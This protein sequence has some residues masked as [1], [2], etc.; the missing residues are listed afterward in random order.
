MK[1]QSKYVI[2]ALVAVAVAVAVV[3]SHSLGSQ[4]S[5]PSNALTEWLEGVLP[6]PTATEEPSPTATRVPPPTPTPR[7]TP[8]VF[9]SMLDI[10]LDLI[11]YTT[12]RSEQR[13]EFCSCFAQEMNRRLSD[14]AEFR[15]LA[16][17]LFP[18]VEEAVEKAEAELKVFR[19]VWQQCGGEAWP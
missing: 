9:D 7:P 1:W 16:A 15:L 17:F 4:E 18:T 10:C 11:P 12:E 13:V 14:E 6:T 8:P 3:F 5:E 19:A 2:V